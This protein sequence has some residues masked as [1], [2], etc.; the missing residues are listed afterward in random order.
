MKVRRS[1]ETEWHRIRD[2]PEIMPPVSAPA[3]SGAGE[4]SATAGAAESPLAQPGGTRESFVFTG[5]W[6]EYFKIWIV[7]VLLTV[8]TLGIYA[9]WA[10]VRKRRYFY[11]NTR[12]FGHTF[13]YL[14]DPVRILYGNLIVAA[15][16]VTYAVL[17]SVAPLLQL[18]FM[19]PIAIVVPWLIIR[20]LAFNARNTAWRGLRFNFTGKYRESAVAF[21]LWPMLVPF[22]FGLIFPLVARRQKEFIVNHHAYGAS[23]FSF[24]GDVGA[25]YRI[26]GI[27]ALFFLPIVAVYFVFVFMLVTGGIRR[28][29]QPSPVQI[30]MF[31]SMGLLFLIAVPLAIAGTFYFRSRMFNYIWNHTSLAGNQFVARMR[32]RDL[33]LLHFVNSLVT[34][35]TAGLLHPWAAIRLCQFQLGSL[36]VIPAGNIDAFV[37]AAQ[38]PVS[39]IG[40][41]ANDFFDFD[42]G[43]GV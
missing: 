25:F 18:A 7:N 26:Y 29:G 20:A 41:A 22:T 11:A 39:A 24:G 33:A 13:E 9:A 43:F 3:S 28:G 1:D 15:L 17:G 38:P 30:Q 34:L 6:T 12:L 10:K 21:L 37:A 36:Q 31:G 19:L 4:S 2:I 16:F 32:A 40:E 42:L 23:P 14:A 27:A 8:V 5:E 35:L